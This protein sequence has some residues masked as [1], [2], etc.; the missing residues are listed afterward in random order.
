MGNTGKDGEILKESQHVE[1]NHLAVCR[2]VVGSCERLGIYCVPERLLRLIHTYHAVPLP[3]RAPKGLYCVF[4]IWFTQ[5]GRVWFTHAMPPPCRSHTMPF[6][7]RL[8]KATAQRGMGTAWYVWI[9]IGHL[10]TACGRPARV[11]LLPV[12]TRSSTK[13]VTVKI[14]SRTSKFGYLRLP[15]GLSRMTRHCRRMAGTRHGMCELTRQGNGI[16]SVN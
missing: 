15:R 11:R 16:V 10:E 4:P 6:W 2:L 13:A 9:S 7:K 8:L 1:W 14:G 12:T 3:C 5:C